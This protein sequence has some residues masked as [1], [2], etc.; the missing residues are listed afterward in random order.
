MERVAATRAEWMKLFTLSTSFERRGMVGRTAAALFGLILI[1]SCGG[2]SPASVDNGRTPRG[3][4][5]PNTAFPMPPATTG[6]AVGNAQSFTLLD[7]RRATLSD[8]SGNVVVLDFW[9]TFCAPC[10][11]EAPHLDALQTRFG[12]QGLRVIGLNVGGPDDHPRIPEFAERLKIKYSL[13]LP[14]PEMIN[15][16]LGSDG[17]IPQTVVFDRKGNVL[18]HFVGYDANISQELESTIKQAVEDVE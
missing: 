6:N 14:E 15:L 16:Y 8:Y 9:A 1:A 17:R 12:P 18:K 4:T 13:G 3:R 7:A 10:L 2:S 5:P 11:E